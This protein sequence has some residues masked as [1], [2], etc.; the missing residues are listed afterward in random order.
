MGLRI[1]GQI[2]DFPFDVLKK[3]PV[4]NGKIGKTPFLV[5]YDVASATPRVFS[6]NVSGK[7]LTYSLKES[8]LIDAETNSVWDPVTGTA[9]KGK[10]KGTQLTML[11]GISSY[12]KAWRSFHP[13]SETYSPNESGGKAK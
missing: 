11:P 13:K 12:I 1:E 9:T 2:V 4:I 10:L 6:R 5:T 8:G 7:M 3:S